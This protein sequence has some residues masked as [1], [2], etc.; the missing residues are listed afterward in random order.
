VWLRGKSEFRTSWRAVALILLLVAVGGGIALAAVAGARRTQT[1]MPRFLAYN[2][3]EDAMLFFNAS[4]A[5]VARVLAQP[6]V[7]QVM[8]LPY[9]YMSADRSGLAEG[10]AVFGAAD[11]VAL[12]AVERPMV[13]SGRAARPDRSSEAM[14]NEVEARRAHL[15]VG[16]R[17]TLYAYSMKQALTAGN[18]GFGHP[19]RPQ[20]PQSQVQVVGIVREPSDIAVVP[21]HQDVAYEG[22]ATI[23]VTPA[24]AQRFAI[25]LGV[26]FA[27]I[28]GNEIVRVRFRH[29]ASDV[30]A[31]TSEATT[32]AGGGVQI[33]ASS[34]IRQR[35]AADQRGISVEVVA[36]LIFAALTA[37]ATILVVI[38]NVARMLRAETPEHLRLS[39]L[40]MT[41]RQRFA[42]ALARP[43]VIAVGGSVCAVFAA[44]VLSPL[45]PIGLARQ[46]ELHPGLALNVAVLGAG[47]VALVV[48]LIACAVVIA[49]RVTATEAKSERAARGRSDSGAFVDRLALNPTARLGVG[50]A[51]SRSNS[52]TTP[53]RAAVVAIALAAAAV[54]AAVTFST[55]LD[56]LSASPRQQGWNFDVVVGNPNTQSDQEAHAIP[57]LARDPYVADY[58]GLAAPAETPTIDGK[59]IGLVGIDVRKGSTGPTI[60]DGR[61]PSAP[62]EIVLGRRSLHVI[63]KNVGD[64]VQ[65]VA[66]PKRLSMRITGVMLNVS[67]GDVFT[68]RFDEGGA[69]T[70]A[71]LRRLEPDSPVVLF[72][73]R[74]VPGVD[75]RAAL[76]RLQHDFGSL[77]LQHVAAQ[78]VE[79]LVRVA[80]LPA[81]L[82]ALLALLA[83][84]TL[85]HTL[86][87]SV[88]RRRD[89]FA[90]LRAIGFIR[91]Q[92]ASTVMWQAWALTFAGV[93]IGVPAGMLIGRWLWRVVA[94]RIGSVQPPA[95]GLSALALVVPIAALVATAVALVPAR[96]A[97]RTGPPTSRRD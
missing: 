32:I 19:S 5:V 50:S 40:G 95:V 53:R 47:F 79:N 64:E 48:V 33:L 84:V 89:E 21:V 67:A 81:L 13:L 22:S 41:R 30:P 18:G 65:V 29:G 24:F 69:T 16:S 52:P 63:H 92:R 20:G 76:A 17:I 9:L 35:A 61:D 72:A 8:R 28:P 93:V 57:L 85:A 43:L 77:V 12:R 39:V 56:H 49:A 42:V 54:A 31:F 6:Q 58:A 75:R 11:D 88:G 27:Q 96:M 7:A 3:P 94:S 60:L 1:A 14:I 78:D 86:L 36:L 4:P 23:Y 37:A 97:A 74:Y 26:P 62:D 44:V 73:V 59:R 87:A 55:S 80:I 34:D 66:G 10:A 71:G 91:R 83:V 82:A 38:L 2:R 25:A 68:G 70:L 15:K 45:T 90:T 51:W 46:A